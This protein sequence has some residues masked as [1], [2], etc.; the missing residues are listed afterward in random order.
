M[1]HHGVEA[2]FFE[3]SQLPIE[4]LRGASGGAIGV[5]T[6]AQIPGAEAEFVFVLSGHKGW[7]DGSGKTRWEERKICRAN[8]ELSVV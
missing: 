7:A 6:F 3:L 2:E 4:S 8:E 5:L 1:K